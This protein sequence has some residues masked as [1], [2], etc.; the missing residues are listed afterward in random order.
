MFSIGQAKARIAIATNASG[1]EERLNNQELRYIFSLRN[2]GELRAPS[3]RLRKA[4]RHC[5]VTEFPS[6]A[7]RLSKGD[8]RGSAGLVI[9]VAGHWMRERPF[10]KA[11]GNVL[12]LRNN[13][14]KT[15][16]KNQSRDTNMVTISSFSAAII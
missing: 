7:N 11:V 1:A 9:I 4:A 12:F 16:E 8:R 5:G 13:H 14:Q 10:L 6:L 3:K 2:T 15:P